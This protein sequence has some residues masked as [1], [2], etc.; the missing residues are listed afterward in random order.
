MVS[1][2]TKTKNELSRLEIEDIDSARA[3][4][5]AIIQISG[6]MNLT[7]LKELDLEIGTENG[8]TSRR[9][10]NLFKMIYDYQPEIEVRKNT[11]LKRTN[12]YINIVSDD[13]M[14]RHILK[15]IGLID[16][17]TNLI[18]GIENRV[19][20][21]FKKNMEMRRAYLRGVFLGGGSLS[22]PEK[23]YHLEFITNDHIFGEELLELLNYFSLNAKT[24]VRKDY[25]IVYIKEGEKIVDFLNI[26]GAHN[27]L[28]KLENIRILKEMRN[29]I[30]R[31]VNCETAN[32][33]K[34]AN[35][36]LRQIQKIEKIQKHMGL[37]TLPDNLRETAELRLEN[38]NLSLAEL[39]ELHNPKVGKSGVNHRLRKL[40]RIADNIK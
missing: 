14:A 29:N 39:G 2:S 33:A 7:G 9:I 10:Y 16:E 36:S 31:I 24:I 18:F 28:L 19:S 30:N 6:Y 23:M 4:L 27:A 3:E 15:D 21:K 5:A 40:E 32:I 35:A 26:I 25:H 34:I 17:D 22:N 1:F 11:N 38:Q 13:G 12:R 37:E 8:A 20:D